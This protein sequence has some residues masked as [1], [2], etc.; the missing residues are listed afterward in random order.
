[1]H[2]KVIYVDC[3][4]NGIDHQVCI[5]CNLQIWDASE[6]HLRVIDDGEVQSWQGTLKVQYEG[7]SS[8]AKKLF[9]LIH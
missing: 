7:H 2:I 3:L 1:M 6:V 9:L 8:P 5:V 4:L